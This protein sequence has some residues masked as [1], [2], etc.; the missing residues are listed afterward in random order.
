MINLN[1]FKSRNEIYWILGIK[2][3]IKNQDDYDNLLSDYRS[4]ILMTYRHNFTNFGNNG[5]TSD[6]GWGCMIRS[7]QMILAE[8]LLRD[9]LGRSWRLNKDKY[10]KHYSIAHKNILY[11]FLDIPRNDCYFSI[12]KII[13]IG[14]KYNKKPGDWYGPE[15]ISNVLKDL[16]NS[17]DLFNIS[18]CALL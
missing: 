10:K 12:H 16:I 13:H 11:Y 6:I 1:N 2:Y 8:V 15:T 3:K 9:K 14:L 5:Y 18:I 4:K 7:G 17:N